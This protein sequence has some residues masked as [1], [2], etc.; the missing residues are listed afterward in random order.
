LLEQVLRD[1]FRAAP[2][3]VATGLPAGHGDP[4]LPLLLG[5]MARLDFDA[6]SPDA[7]ATARLQ[8]V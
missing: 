5:R 3:P 7:T 6:G 8:M 4:N 2:F 1:V